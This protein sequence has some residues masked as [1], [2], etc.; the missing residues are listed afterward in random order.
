MGFVKRKENQLNSGRMGEKRSSDGTVEKLHLAR[1]LTDHLG[2]QTTSISAQ[3]LRRCST[4]REEQ[5]YG[6]RSCF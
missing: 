5:S 4:R 3:I 2:G 1:T 6:G